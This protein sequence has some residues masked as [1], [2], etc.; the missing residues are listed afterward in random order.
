MQDTVI[1]LHKDIL[2]PTKFKSISKML[3]ERLK[4]FYYSKHM[5][6]HLENLT[7]DRSH[8]YFNGDITK[9]DIDNLIL[10]LNKTQRE[11]FEVELTNVNG[12][13][14][15]TKYCCRI[16]F[17]NN[18]D[19]VVAIRPQ[20]GNKSMVVTAW[21]NATEDKHFTLDESKYISKEDVEAMFYRR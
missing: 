17:V 19:L 10:S 15:V 11:V 2:I 21:L 16:P 8:K 3:Q 9:K 4:D 6:E 7:P 13:W 5:Q 1:L 18:Q 20:G 12:I 14:R